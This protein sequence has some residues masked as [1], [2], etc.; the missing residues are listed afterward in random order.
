ML[1]SQEDHEIFIDFDFFTAT[2]VHA[3]TRMQLNIPL[4]PV[5]KFKLMATFPEVLMPVVWLEEGVWLPDDLV[6][7]VKMA[8]T[9]MKAVG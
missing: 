3:R 4:M 5:E 1:F 9:A 6:K 7:Q 2:P 8:H